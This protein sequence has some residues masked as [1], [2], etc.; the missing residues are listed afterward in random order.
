MLQN[1]FCW[2]EKNSDAGQHMPQLPV[3]M[4]WTRSEWVVSQVVQ[5]HS[6]LLLYHYT[7]LL[8]SFIL[9]LGCPF[10]GAGDRCLSVFFISWFSVLMKD[11]SDTDLYCQPCLSFQVT[12][13]MGNTSLHAINLVSTVK[14]LQNA[15]FST[16][17][18]QK[19]AISLQ[20][21]WWRLLISPV[22]QTTQL[23]HPLCGMFIMFDISLNVRNQQP[24]QEACS[25][26][27]L[28]PCPVILLQQST[29]DFLW[30]LCHFLLVLCSLLHFT[31]LF[32]SNLVWNFVFLPQFCTNFNV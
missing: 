17:R 15:L 26:C 11:S 18:R 27:L 1:S 4:A 2:S 28:S 12:I 3:I 13:Q 23:V 16:L 8:L 24:R 29:V 20:W 6:L 30:H 32:Y 19:T 21:K 31:L 9:Y 7:Y 5:Y 25:L 14:Q 22:D 10:M